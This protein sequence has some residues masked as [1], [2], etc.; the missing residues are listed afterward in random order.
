MQAFLSVSPFSYKR[1]DSGGLRQLPLDVSVCQGPLVV[2]TGNKL[3]NG[4]NI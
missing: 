1:W 3:S 4:E 2:Y